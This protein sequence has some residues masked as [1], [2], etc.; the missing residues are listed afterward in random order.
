MG[1]SS[2]SPLLLVLH[3]VMAAQFQPCLPLARVWKKT[4][5]FWPGWDGRFC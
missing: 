2:G 3:W 4:M 1:C 5:Q